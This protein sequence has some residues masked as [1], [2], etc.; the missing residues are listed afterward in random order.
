MA[1]HTSFFN[2]LNPIEPIRLV[3][4]NER[5]RSP[6]EGEFIISVKKKQS[7][8]SPWWEACA[9]GKIAPVGVGRL[10]VLIGQ[11]DNHA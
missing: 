9:C 2:E 10:F 1:E 5:W 7:A 4:N 3:G 8:C 11:T 6:N